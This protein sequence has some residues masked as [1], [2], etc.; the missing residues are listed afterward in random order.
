MHIFRENILRQSLSLL[1][2]PHGLTVPT[3]SVITSTNPVG[4]GI[5]GEDYSITCTVMGA[6]T[7][8]ATFNIMWLRLGGGVLAM[9][10]STESS[11]THT[12]TPVGES[13]EGLYTCEA[14]VSSTLLSG[15]LTPPSEMLSVTVTSKYKIIIA[16]INKNLCI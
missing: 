1:P 9:E 16:G 12:F 15:V 11:L 7:L 3:V 4:S 8:G 6:E 5:A 14:T 2:T 13:D 10:T